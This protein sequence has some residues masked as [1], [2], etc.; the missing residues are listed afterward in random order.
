MKKKPLLRRARKLGIIGVLLLS[1][2]LVPV[3]AY[4]PE[5]GLL[6][7]NKRKHIVRNYLV[8]SDEIVSGHIVFA[9]QSVEGFQYSV[10]VRGLQPGTTYNVRA[11]S[12][13]LVHLPPPIGVVPSSDGGGNTYLLGSITTDG[14]GEGE[15]SGLIT[16]PA[17][18]LFLPFG[19]YGWEIKVADQ[20]SNDVLWTIP[21]GPGFDPIDFV[22]FP[23]W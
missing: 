5:Y 6:K 15:V 19:L 14:E 3:L 12:M 17:S 7:E 9:C 4:P 2:I 20:S 10:A 23:S 21:I 18:H 22:V 13:A 16:L 11:E 8:D 1:L